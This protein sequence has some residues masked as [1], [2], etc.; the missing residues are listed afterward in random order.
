LSCW[1]MGLVSKRGKW[2][3]NRGLVANVG[4]L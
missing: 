2:A 3:V 1:A 4:G